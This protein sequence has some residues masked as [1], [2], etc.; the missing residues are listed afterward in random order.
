MMVCGLREDLFYPKPTNH[1]PMIKPSRGNLMGFGYWR[2]GLIL[3]SEIFN[4]LRADTNN[5]KLLWD[6]VTGGLI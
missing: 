6:V 3:E 2:F 1:N 4:I 5:G